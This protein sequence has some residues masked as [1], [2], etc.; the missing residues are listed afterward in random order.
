MVTRSCTV[1]IALLASLLVPVTGPSASAA[2]ATFVHPGVVVSRPQLDFMRTK[3]QAGA[4]P[5]KTAYDR[6]MATKYADLNRTP[7]PRAVVE[8]GPVSNPNNG[9]TDEREDA[10]AAYTLSLA[11]YV[12]RDARYATKAIQI[13]D[14]WSATIRDHTNSNAPLQTA[15]SASSWPKAAEIIKHVYGTWPN[16]A[17]FGTM[18]RNVYL[19]EIQNGRA[20]T[21][22][23]WELSMMEASIGIAVYLED[24]AAYDKAIGI[25]RT[26]IQAFIYLTTDG[27]LPRTPPG[28]G[29]D[30]R[31]EIIS[32]WHNQSTFVDGLTQET[33]RDFAHTA[34]GLSAASHLA[35]T[36]WIQ[37]QDIW[38][39]IKDRM[40]HAW[41]LHSKYQ[42]GEPMPSWLCG[43]TLSRE[44]G[45]T[46]EVSY[47]ALNTRLGIAMANT[48]IYTESKRPH[49]TDNLF[50]AWETLTHAANP[51]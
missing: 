35:E 33:C 10:L 8:C 12:T 27:A 1:L 21:N 40:R 22:G 5:W 34:Y 51:S 16:S 3:V 19:P 11:W 49:G 31:A 15:W 14:A 37:G 48:K 42:N 25:F 41:G 36:A 39:E 50:I 23:N 30:T 26:R 2:P 32:Y 6:M 43:G 4:Q 45:P 44:L 24:K 18:L 9:C 46:P 47:N 38:G 29:I 20:N 28:S 17:R 7:K 13:M